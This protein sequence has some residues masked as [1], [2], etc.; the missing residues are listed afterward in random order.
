MGNGRS[1]RIFLF[2]ARLIVCITIDVADEGPLSV[3]SV[4]GAAIQLR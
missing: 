4:T 1:G 2:K 3:S